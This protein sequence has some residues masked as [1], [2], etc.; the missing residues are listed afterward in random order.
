MMLC[1]ASIAAN[2]L[3]LIPDVMAP[4]VAI[5]AVANELVLPG[6]PWSVR[7]FSSSFSNSSWYRPYERLCYAT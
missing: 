3:G 6:T 2:V 4:T 1:Y 5:A 7:S